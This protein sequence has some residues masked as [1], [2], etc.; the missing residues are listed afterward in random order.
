M[1]ER[2][3]RLAERRVAITSVVRYSRET[4]ISGCLRVLDL[5]RGRLSFVTPSPEST[6]RQ[7]DP[8]PR[9][10]TRG[11]RG[12]SV[13]G[14]RI[15]IANAERLFVFDTSWNLVAELSNDLMADVHD[16]LAEERGIWA[17]ATG[18]DQLLLVGW[19]GELR[20]A[21][22]FR[23]ERTLLKELGFGRRALPKAA[24]ILDLRDPRERNSGYDRLHLNSLG[25]G[26]SGLLLSFGRVRPSEELDTEYSSALVRATENGSGSPELELLHRQA[27]VR[28]PS[29]NVA[30]DGDLLVYNDSSRHRLVAWDTA[31]NEA[32]CEVPIPGSPPYARG[33]ARI[34]DDL[35]LVGSQAPLSVHAVD[36]R[37]AEVVASYP[38][39]G[40]QDEVV[41][42][43]CPLPDRFADPRQP[44]SDDPYEFWRRASLGVTPVPRRG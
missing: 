26:A 31:R 43:I 2:P 21:W 23:K 35:W 12:V 24:P 1:P 20:Y 29:H 7:A 34:G 44:L 19:D 9:G 16:V 25:R 42:A 5:D 14:D 18:I 33:L 17:A 3:E 11:T 13:F 6:F 8:N 32:R 36:L 10:G 4:E 28:L 38:L 22:S 40:I 30:E 27:G 39:A 41:F 37:R 15:V